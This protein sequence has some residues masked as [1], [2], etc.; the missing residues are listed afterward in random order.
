MTTLRFLAAKPGIYSTIV[1]HAPCTA[2]FYAH[3]AK[4]L[5]SA[6]SEERSKGFSI[7]GLKEV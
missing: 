1:R 4:G 6:R 3:A 2:H 7:S 5:Y